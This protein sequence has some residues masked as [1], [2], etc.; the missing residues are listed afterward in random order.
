MTRESSQR[1]KR[2]EETAAAFLK[3][4]GYEI[5]EMNFRTRRGEVDIIARHKGVLAFVE[6][7]TRASNAFGSPKGA[8]GREKQRRISMAALEYLS[9]TRQT[10][11]RAR[12]DV[13]SV[14][15]G[16]AG[17]QVELISNAFELAYR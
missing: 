7:K 15:E 2:G 4:Q 14:L 6:V 10:R 16:E 9:R 5:L 3:K 11:S 12:F 8:V 13:V 1:G 17:T